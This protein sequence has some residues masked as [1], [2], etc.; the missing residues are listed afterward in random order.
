MGRFVYD[1]LKAHPEV[2][3]WLVLERELHRHAVQAE[4]EPGHR[5]VCS[6]EE[7]EGPLLFAVECAGHEAV[8]QVVPQLLGR[9]VTTVVASVGALANSDVAQALEA[10]C[11]DGCSQLLLVPGALAGVDAL[12]AARSFGL[13][14]VR[15]CGRK[16]PRSWKRTQAEQLCDLDALGEATTFFRGTAREAALAFP[17]NA[18]VAAMI[19]LAGI[20]LDAT[21]VELIADPAATCNTHTV[22]ASGTF[23]SMEIRISASAFAANPKT[24]ALAG[25]SVI[26]TVQNRLNHVVI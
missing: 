13:E 14:S 6:L 8:R 10:A 2:D 21:Q 7:V 25:M 12:A 4:L 3:R 1:H 26:R 17:Q 18:N 20:G 5:V 9:G 19:G 16:P 11:G 24:S 15:Y 22:E 23:G